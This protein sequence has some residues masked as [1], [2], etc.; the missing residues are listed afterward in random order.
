MKYAT[1]IERIF[2]NLYSDAVEVEVTDTM[3]WLSGD[4]DEHTD[5]TTYKGYIWDAYGAM[6]SFDAC[7]FDNGIRSFIVHDSEDMALYIFNRG[8]TTDDVTPYYIS[9][10]E[11]YVLWNN[12][13]VNSDYKSS[14]VINKIIDHFANYIPYKPNHEDMIEAII[15]NTD[16]IVP[17]KD[18]LIEY[19]LIERD[20]L[21]R[22][23]R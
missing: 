1:I 6:L 20:I 10:E 23:K 2:K 7:R 15:S 4:M 8:E 5:L 17:T 14:T 18:E 3:R 19:L 13:T 16:C 11:R 12:V 9:Y 21:K 22:N